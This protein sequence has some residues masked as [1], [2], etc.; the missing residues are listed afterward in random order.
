M[1]VTDSKDDVGSAEDPAQEDATIVVT[2]NVTEVNEGPTFAVDA[3]ATQEVPENTDTDSNIGTPYTA[4][5]PENDTPLTYSL[6]GTDAASF[7]IDTEPANSRRK[8]TWT[9]RPRT[10][11]ASTVQVSD[12]KDASTGTDET[13]PE[14]DTT[15]PVTITVTN[16]EEDG[17][18]TF[19][20]DPPSAGHCPDGDPERR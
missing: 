15:H 16:V 2:I 11:T 14:V 4:T 12:G 10:A 13:P 19:S 9:T 3:R 8:P 20:S 5:D 18:I 1:S 17:T 7:A 6:G